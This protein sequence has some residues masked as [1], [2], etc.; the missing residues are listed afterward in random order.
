MRN[1]RTDRIGEKGENYGFLPMEI[2]EYRN[3]KDITVLFPATGERVRTRY[4]HFKKGRVPCKVVPAMKKKCIKAVGAA[5][6]G[7]FV[8]LA[9]L[10][11]IL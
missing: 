5:I 1:K 11:L 10:L 2:V 8:L 6:I 7:V 3:N 4:E 9:S